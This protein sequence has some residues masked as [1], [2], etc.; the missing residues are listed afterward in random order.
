MQM[1]KNLIITATALA[2]FIVCPRM[3]AIIHVI[4]KNSNQPLFKTALIG[5]IIAIPLILMMVFIFSKFGITGALMFCIVTDLIS[6]CLLGGIDRKA[7]VETI[8]IAAFV[9]A[10][11]KVAPLVAN[12]FVK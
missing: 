3:A 10:A 4:C 6:A 5:S 11:V 9:F 2:F 8:V 7:G 12:I 1:T